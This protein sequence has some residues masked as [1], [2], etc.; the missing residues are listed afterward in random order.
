MPFDAK[1]AHKESESGQAL[2]EFALVLLFVILPVMFVMTDSAMTL[3]T[4]AVMT[5]AA[6]EGARGGSIYQATTAPAFSDTFDVQV[7]NI[8]NARAAYIQQE[9]QRMIGPLVSYSECTTTITYTPS[10]PELGNPYRQMDSLSLSLA[11]PRRLFFGL[12]GTN[13]IILRAQSTRRIEPG[14]VAPPPAGP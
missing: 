4:Y 14:G 2:V 9:T 8:D 13:Q 11:C 1:H 5:N 7:A 6:R 12:I 10:T 3:Y